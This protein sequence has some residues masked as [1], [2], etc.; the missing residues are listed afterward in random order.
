[1]AL[2]HRRHFVPKS[3]C[4]CAA[5]DNESAYLQLDKFFKNSIEV[6]LTAGTDYM[7]LKA[8]G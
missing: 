4:G 7:Q 6:T 8:E 3:E 5:A 1:M 2:I